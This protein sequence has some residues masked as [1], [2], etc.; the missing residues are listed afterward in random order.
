MF[1]VCERGLSTKEILEICIV[2]N[3]DTKKV[4]SGV[5]QGVTESAIFVIVLNKVEEKDLT[6]DGNGAYERHSCPTEVVT[7]EF[8][9]ESK[10]ES[11][12]KLKWGKNFRGNSVFCVKR[13]YSWHSSCDEFCPIVTKVRDQ[14]KGE[15]GRYAIIQYKVTEKAKELFTR[16]S[17]GNAKVREE[18]YIRTKPSVISKIKLYAKETAPKHVVTKVQSE[19]GGVCNFQSVSDIPRNRKQVYNQASKIPN[20]IRSR[21]T[22]PQKAADFTP[23]IAKLQTNDFIKD[24]SFGLR[25]GK[26]KDTSPN[27]FAARDLHLKWL[28]TFCSGTNPKSQCGI[29]MTYN[30]G[31]FYLTTLTF[32]HPMFVMRD[33]RHKHPTTLAAVMT[34][35]SRETE[36]YEYLAGNLKRKGINT[37]T[38]GTD[39]ET[40]LEMGFEKVFP[41]EGTS[42]S[43]TNI[44]L[45]CFDHVKTD[46]SI[47]LTSLKVSS[48]KQKEIIRE[49]IGA[50]YQGKRV[51]GLV[52]CPTEADFDREIK[53][54]EQQWPK[55]FTAWLHSSEGRFR[56]LSETMRKCM[57]R[58]VRVAAGLGNPPNKWQN[59]RTESINNIIKEEINRQSTDQVTIHELIETHVIQP[60]LDELVKAIYQMGEYRLSEEYSHLAVDPLQWSQMTPHQRDARIKMV[61]GC[62]LPSSRTDEPITRKLSINLDDCQLH[63]H[64]PSYE[65][66]EI[67]KKAETILSNY[68][69]MELANGNYCVIEY[70]SSFTVETKKGK[71]SNCKNCKSFRDTGGLCPHVL[72]VAEKQGTLQVFIDSYKKSSNKLGKMIK[73]NLPKQLG[74]KPQQ[75]KKPRRGGNNISQE[76]IQLEIDTSDLISPKPARYTEYYQNDEPFQVV[77][78]QDH[79][80]AVKCVGC[81]NDFPKKMP[82]APYDIAL[83]HE[84]RYCYPKTD[85]RGNTEMV[86]TRVKRAKRFY[87]IDKKCIL[88]RHPYFW[89]GLVQVTSEVQERLK[90]SHKDLLYAML[91]YRI[92][93][94]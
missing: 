70:D 91:R 22:G 30:C 12:R 73:A 21:G 77:F 50:E 48:S 16:K 34:S 49:A 9:E 53:L 54:D 24:V 40:P 36:D 18:G 42:S 63:V 88:G 62:I 20:R 5:P 51:N 27:T 57:L 2:G 72:V 92:E 64:C 56:P 59:Q 71:I 3:I 14:G 46:M 25:H 76:P 45:R 90:D 68:N 37:L 38:Y 41:I 75:Q 6:T 58:P 82:I 65:L 44:H 26:R 52:D 67:W 28:K 1:K 4:C 60:H 74:G 87:C 23:L 32:P 7:A 86:P 35:V 29:D 43:D 13:Q 84:E 66:K 17:H 47:K 11:L 79:K 94:N 69:V 15:L 31:P 89:R 83:A 19:A 93:D 8:T 39:G 33:A 80:N 10:I 61:F 85:D 78:I 81:S 55:D